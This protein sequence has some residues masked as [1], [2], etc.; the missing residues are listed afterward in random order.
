MEEVN[1][2]EH[3]GCTLCIYG[4][5]EGETRE[6]ER[7]I[8]DREMIGSLGRLKREGQLVRK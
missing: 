7:A 1:E 8:Q 4:S 5:M 6:R 3:L 2:F